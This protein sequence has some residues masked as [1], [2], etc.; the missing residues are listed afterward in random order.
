MKPNDKNRLALQKMWLILRWFLLV[1]LLVLLLSAFDVFFDTFGW[2]TGFTEKTL[3]DWLDLLIIPAVLALGVLWVNWI[4]QRNEQRRADRENQIEREIASERNQET[5][6]QT[7]L[8][9]MTEL[10]L[11]ENLRNSQPED[12]VRTVAK[13]RTLT[14]LRSLEKERKNT[15]LGFLVEAELGGDM[16]LSPTAR[17]KH[18]REE[19]IANG[20]ELISQPQ[21][22]RRR[23]GLVLF[24][25]AGAFK[26]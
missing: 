1:S 26:G 19:D 4:S 8:D 25:P 16:R 7:Y 5:V 22:H 12:E 20:K 23:A 21:G 10:L 17:G 13:T 2:S 18:R 11:K 9:R 24:L 15:V 6:L 14:I 3:W